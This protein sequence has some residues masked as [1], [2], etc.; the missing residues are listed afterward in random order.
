MVDIK[1]ALLSDRARIPKRMT[2]GSAGYDLYA[3]VDTVV[4]AATIASS[5]AVDVGRCLVPIGFAI[6]LPND[7]VGRIAARSSLSVKFNLEVGAGWIDSDF[8]GEVMVEL[9]NL[10]STDYKVT[11]GD[12][13]AQL[14]LLMTTTKAEFIATDQIGST[15]R[16]TSGLGSTG[17]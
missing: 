1:I 5:G 11:A 6:E 15:A 10:S 13:I 17:R 8:R 2:D 3:A 4:P 9:K 7:I 12:R 16:G 14:I